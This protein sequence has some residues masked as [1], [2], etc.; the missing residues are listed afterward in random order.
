MENPGFDVEQ[1]TLGG[2]FGGEAS[3]SD[4]SSY[5][6]Y[7][8]GTSYSDSFESDGDRV[9]EPEVELVGEMIQKGLDHLLGSSCW[10]LEDDFNSN[11]DDDLNNDVDYDKYE[12]KKYPLFNPQTDMRNPILIKGY[13][14]GFI[15]A[16]KHASQ[17]LIEAISLL[18][19]NAEARNCARHLY[20]NFKNI[21]G[22]R[23]QVM[24]LTYWKAAKATFPRQFEEAMSEMRSLSKSAE[25]WLRD[26]DPRT[27][28]R[29]HF[30]TRCKFDL[31]LNNNNECFNKI[32]LE[33]RDKPILTMLEI[34]RRKVMT[35][36]VSMREAAEKYP[37]PLCP[38]IQKKLFE[39]ASQSN[40]IWPVYA[41]NEKYEVDCGLGN[42]HVVDLFNSS[43]SC[44]KWDLSGIPCKHVVSCMQLLAVSPET[45]INTC[46]TVTTQL[47]IY[48]H[49][50]NPV[51]GPIQWEHVRDME[52]IIPPIIRR[53]TGRPKQTRRK[54]VGEARKSGPKL[55][56]IGQ[57]ANCTKY[58]KPGHNTRTCKRIVGGIQMTSQSLSLQISN[59]A[60]SMDNTSSQPSLTQQSSNLTANFRAKLPFKR[61]FVL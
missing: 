12:N 52:P 24:R 3:D 39:I 31:L 37:G 48:S 21:E 44:R 32:I 34:I 28:S 40:N 14:R 58:G 16:L 25:A 10:G 38:R 8:S 55:S 46:S 47:N 29:A 42:K 43:C 57:Q 45:Y 54:E 19:P 20:N 61:K 11:S 36:L 56:K 41:G 27:W 9:D 30:S 49:L 51:K 2:D 13:F 17:G 59:Q 50:I 4:D 53:P 60:T 22:F 18:F 1:N 26:K 35:R 23:G 33:A 5:K 6:A 15:Y 7:E